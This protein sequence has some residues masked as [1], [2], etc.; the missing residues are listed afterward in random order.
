MPPPPPLPEILFLTRRYCGI[1]THYLH[2]LQGAGVRLRGG[3]EVAGAGLAAASLLLS[4]AARR[5]VRVGSGMWDA[6]VQVEA[7][8]FTIAQAQGTHTHTH[9]RTHA[10]TH[11]HAAQPLPLSGLTIHALDIDAPAHRAWRARH[12]LNVPVLH[13]PPPLLLL[14]RAPSDVLLAGMEDGAVIALLRA[15]AALAPPSSP[16]DVLPPAPPS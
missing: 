9:A 5:Q 7:S 6:A 2:L 11:T 13:F 8:L 15:Y 14:D 1:C 12:H 3:R 16:P 10:R 4:P